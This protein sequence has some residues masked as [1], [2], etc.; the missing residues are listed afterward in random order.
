MTLDPDR[1]EL[2]KVQYFVD[3]LT[4]RDQHL[5]MMVDPA[6]ATGRTEDDVSSYSTLQNGYAQ[7]VFYKDPENSNMTYEGVVWPGPTAFPDWTAE[8]A[9][10]WWTDEM[11]AFFDPETGVNIS[12]VWID[13]NEPASFLPYLEANVQ[14]IS[15]ER[16]VPPVRPAP[17]V[18]AATVEGFERFTAGMNVS[19]PFENGNT[20]TTTKRHVLSGSQRP[21]ARQSQE[22]NETMADIV[23]P[24]LDSQWLYPP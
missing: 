20:S 1:F 3:T 6:V 18:L 24:G 11:V 15:M 9:R 13:M 8:S 21:V 22:S 12:G 5:I 19:T 14:R 7:E 4:A 16:E 17:R 23:D 2:A 10:Q